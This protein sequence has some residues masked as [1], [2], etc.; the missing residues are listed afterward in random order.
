MAFLQLRL[1]FVRSFMQV[2]ESSRK[3]PVCENEEYY[4]TGSFQ[5]KLCWFYPRGG[6]GIDRAI[7]F[8]PPA[9]LGLLGGSNVES[10]R[11]ISAH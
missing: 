10:D 5:T 1:G 9:E 11:A 6:S 7:A 2:D 8:P 4:G 3:E